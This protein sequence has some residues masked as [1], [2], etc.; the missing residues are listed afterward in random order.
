MQQH[1]QEALEE[2]KTELYKAQIIIYYDIDPNTTTILQCD[3]STLI[4][5]VWIRQINQRCVEKTVGMA[6]RCL[7]PTVKVLQNRKKVVWQSLMAYKKWI[8]PTLVKGNSRNRPFTTW[9]NLP[10]KS[11]CDSIQTSMVHR[12]APKICHPSQAQIRKD[13]SSC[14]RLVKSASMK[15]EKVHH[16]S[17][18]LISS[19]QTWK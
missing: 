16:N 11:S 10:E 4:V 7:T 19:W 8:F 18:V 2:I 3:A 9:T 12:K 14:R 13:N 1:H 15:I 6:S 17:T 5:G